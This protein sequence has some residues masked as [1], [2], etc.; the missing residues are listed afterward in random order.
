MDN[1]N[2]LQILLL[3]VAGGADI[4]DSVAQFA[5]RRQCGVCVFGG[6]GTVAN[7]TLRQPAAP[8]EV[9]T[10]HGCFEILS[11]TGSFLP[12]QALLGLSGLT[13]NLAGAQGQVVGGKVVGTFV[14]EGPVRV[15][16]C[17]FSNV[18]Y[19]RLPLEDNHDNGSAGL[20]Q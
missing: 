4:A 11:L 17:T 12:P 7:I 18:I 8:G 16:A 5:R 9:M 10:L 20:L 3:N 1:S 2:A 6:I 13:V 14:A 15:I 19:E